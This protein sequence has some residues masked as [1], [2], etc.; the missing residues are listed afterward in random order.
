M[1]G[2]LGLQTRLCLIAFALF[3]S[4]PLSAQDHTARPW[5]LTGDVQ[6]SGAVPIVMP[7]SNSS[8]T[9]I[10]YFVAEGQ[11]VK[12]GEAVLRIDAGA[13]ASLSDLQ[14]QIDLTQARVDKDLATLRVVAVNAEIAELDAKAANARA[15]LDAAVPKTYLSPLDFD[16]FAAEAARSA[17]DFLQK[18]KVLSSARAAVQRKAEDAQLELNKAKVELA[19]ALATAERSEVKATVS[20][21]VTHGFSEGRGGGRRYDE[22]E[23]AQ[24]GVVVGQVLNGDRTFVRAYALEADRLYLT[25]T[26]AVSLSV[27]ALPNLVIT[28]DIRS[29]SN[30]PEAR[31]AW[32]DGR[33][34]RVDIELPAEF[35]GKLVPGMSV[36]ITDAALT[37]HPQL[38]HRKSALS[39]SPIALDNAKS[40]AIPLEIEGELSAG[41]TSIIAPPTV[42]DLW[43]LTLQTLIPEG[44]MVSP[45]QAIAIFD[46]QTLVRQTEENKGRLAEV[47]RALE[48]LELDQAQ[49][50]RTDVLAQALLVSEA[51]KAARKAAQPQA[52]VGGIASKKLLID[53]A[54]AREKQML[55][56]ALLQSQRSARA[57]ELRDLQLQRSQLEGKI[58]DLNAALAKMSVK[59]TIAGMVIHNVGFNGD[60]FTSGSQ[61]YMGQAVAQVADLNSLRVNAWVPEALSSQV[62]VGMQAQVLLGSGARTLRGRVSRLGLAFRSKSRAQPVIVRDVTVELTDLAQ[63]GAE[64][65]RALKPGT[66]VRVS[67][68]PGAK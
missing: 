39:N 12:I 20:G 16:R 33:Y 65:Q 62:E 41:R 43:Q 4:T 30:A 2:L 64:Q 66:A 17:Q 28:A 9:L 1:S 53:K 3:I 56:A 5:I 13:L 57:A 23:I 35:Q 52:L 61:I 45:D 46:G 11:T 22:G 58:A 27:D 19:F 59:P 31:A 44:T 67:I 7:P 37:L 6:A 10:R 48:K 14:A 49:A 26:Q 47:A 25:E 18:S 60:K 63:F 42:K 40:R 24:S 55:S 21:M 50:E 38:A 36:R 68:M 29:I 32:G 51:E 34:F 15:K 54:S 8:P